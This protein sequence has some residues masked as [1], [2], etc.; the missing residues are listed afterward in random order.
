MTQI[1]TSVNTAEDDDEDDDGAVLH[2]V[3]LAKIASDSEDSDIDLD[4]SQE[5]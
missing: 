4:E 3:D 5:I 2:Q 1:I